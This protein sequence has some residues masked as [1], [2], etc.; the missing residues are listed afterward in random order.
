M[1]YRIFG[2]AMSKIHV[3]MTAFDTPFERLFYEDFNGG[4]LFKGGYIF[5]EIFKSE[6]IE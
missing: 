5:V 6:A 1:K 2:Q 4:F 3:V